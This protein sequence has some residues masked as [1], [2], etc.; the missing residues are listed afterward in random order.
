MV[1]L[2]T[3]HDVGISSVPQIG[4]SSP[5]VGL[6]HK[7][8]QFPAGTFQLPSLPKGSQLKILGKTLHKDLPDARNSK[9]NLTSSPGVGRGEIPAGSLWKCLII[10]GSSRACPATPTIPPCPSLGTFS[11]NVF[12]IFPGIFSNYSWNSGSLGNVTF[13]VFRAQHSLGEE[14]P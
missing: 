6:E 12:Q 1:L 13:P 14:P 8:S 7:P 10:P 2:E 4:S 3:F 9:K 11:R 5:K